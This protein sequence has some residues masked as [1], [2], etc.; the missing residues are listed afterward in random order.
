MTRP[1]MVLLSFLFVPASLGQQAPT[2]EALR[3]RAEWESG[4]MG[5]RDRAPQWETR[6]LQQSFWP[7]HVVFRVDCNCGEGA[8]APPVT[9]AVSK[10]GKTALKLANGDGVPQRQEESRFRSFRRER[11]SPSETAGAT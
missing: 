7:G 5:Y 2:L 1:A 9:V 4:L 6:V 8:G 11:L 3:E 10:G